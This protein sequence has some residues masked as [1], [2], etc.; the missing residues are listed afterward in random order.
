[1]AKACHDDVLDALLLYVADN[2]KRITVC[3]QQPTTYTEAITT[4][5]LADVDTTEG[6]GGGD[7]SVANGDTSGRKLT[8]AQQSDI[9]VDSTGS[10]THIALVDV[11]NSKLLYVTT[12]TAQ[13]ITSGNTVTIPAFDIE[14]AD[15]S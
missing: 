5:K 2:T 4:Y 3:S 8:V 1:M 10:A 14:V 9:P 13:T 11:D 12:C 15:P 7:F 6:T